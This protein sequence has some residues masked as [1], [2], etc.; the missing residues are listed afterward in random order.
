MASSMKEFFAS[1]VVR[2]YLVPNRSGDSSGDGWGPSKASTGSKGPFNG[3][4]K[5]YTT[6]Q[7]EAFPTGEQLEASTVLFSFASSAEL[8]E[9]E[10][11]VPL[12]SIRIGTEAFSIVYYSDL[13][14]P[15]DRIKTRLVLKK[16]A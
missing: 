7:N 8:F 10:P 15:V 5:T 3:I 14:L 16:E 13:P 1:R 6:T 2:F 9:A 12:T 4:V 11:E